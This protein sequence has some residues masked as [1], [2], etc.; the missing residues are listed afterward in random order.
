MDGLKE[1]FNNN[2]LTVVILGNEKT[3]SD[4]I[5]SGLFIFFLCL[6]FLY[7]V[8]QMI[9][10]RSQY[11]EMENCMEVFV[12]ISGFVALLL[13]VITHKHVTKNWILILYCFVFRKFV[14]F[15][16]WKCRERGTWLP[17]TLL[18]LESALLGLY[19]SS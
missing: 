10:L 8:F 13:E 16:I 5:F 9:T 11:I 4:W 6:L 15:L 18:L 3:T 19:S 17:E 1:T 7:E 2:W 14:K 12:F